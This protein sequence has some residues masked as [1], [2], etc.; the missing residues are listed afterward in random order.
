MNA[1]VKTT[2]T[3]SADPRRSPWNTRIGVITVLTASLAVIITV[4]FALYSTA[5]SKFQLDPSHS[6]YPVGVKDHSQP[7][8]EAPPAANAMTGY[9]LSYVSNFTGSKLPPGWNIYT[10]V[11]GGVPGGQFGREHVVVSGGLLRLNTWK[12][13]RYQNRWVTGGLCQCELAR[14]YG[15][16]FV[17]SRVTGP[18]PHEIQLLWPLSNKW[19]PEIDFNETAGGVSGSS[20]TLHYGAINTIDQ[21]KIKIDMKQWH[22]W[23]VIWTP[24]SISYVVDGQVWGVI[25]QG[26]E[27]ARVPMTLDMQQ[28]AKCVPGNCSIHRASMLVDWVA[29]YTHT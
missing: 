18:G 27:I 14:T 1:R 21:R 8:G 5:N 19:P 15:A 11:P 12:D 26:F 6:V 20:S 3:K 10:G 23:G 25:N 24:T 13:P 28:T 4:L 22:T 7:S 2:K 17:R 16:Y 9:K 29:E